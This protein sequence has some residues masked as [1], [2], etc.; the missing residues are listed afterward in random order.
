MFIMRRKE[1]KRCSNNSDTNCYPC[2][3]LQVSA[4]TSKGWGDY[5][6]PLEVP[7]GQAGEYKYDEEGQCRSFSPSRL[8]VS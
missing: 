1:E 7:T 2:F 6:D 3:V 5:S 4:Q 8:S